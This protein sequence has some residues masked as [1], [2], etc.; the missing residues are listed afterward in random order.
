M[1]PC[2]FDVGFA[3]DT[4]AATFSPAA[5][6]ASATAAVG[7]FAAIDATLRRRLRAMPATLF[8]RYARCR[9]A[10][11]LRQSLCQR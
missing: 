5:A 8:T 6:R 1:S 2:Y 9:R 4:A 7:V 11:I 3:I 10:L